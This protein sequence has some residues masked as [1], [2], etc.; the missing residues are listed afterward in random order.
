M[1][2]GDGGG[3]ETHHYRRANPGVQLFA[4]NRSAFDR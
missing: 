4:E 1:D 3:P 2:A